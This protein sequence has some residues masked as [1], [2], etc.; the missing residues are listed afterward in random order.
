MGRRKALQRLAA[1]GL[2]G[3]ASLCLPQTGRAS[4][5]L[6]VVAWKGQ[7]PAEELAAFSESTGIGVETLEVRS[8]HDFLN[9]MEATGGRE[10]DMLFPSNTFASKWEDLGLL[11]PFSQSSL[12]L[13][14]IHPALMRAAERDWGFGNGPMW[15]PHLWTGELVCWSGKAEWPDETGRPSYGDLWNPEG[16]RAAAGSAYSLL[17]AAGLHLERIGALPENA[18]AGATADNFRMRQV[19]DRI[20]AWCLDRKAALSRLCTT[21]DGPCLPS[22][23]GEAALAADTAVLNLR[24]KAGPYDYG[25][26]LEG[27]LV[28]ASGAVIPLGARN[29]EEAHVFLAHFLAAETA[30][31]CQQSH[32][33][34]PSSAKAAEAMDES[35]RERF[36][37]V[38]SAE[39]IDSAYV[40]PGEP[41]WFRQRKASYVERFV[42]ALSEPEGSVG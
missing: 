11:R 36:E 37:S 23:R 26:A 4:G 16:E 13:D 33:L 32:G 9:L 25:A 8:D 6:D 20:Y 29:V 7:F 12:P 41:D 21:E 10:F 38:Y 28:V 35:K 40:F 18:V 2:A 31:A 22:G 17:V 3:S 27:P 42:Q 34:N 15:I 5:I 19:W 30:A 39:T 24:G 14:D 1:L